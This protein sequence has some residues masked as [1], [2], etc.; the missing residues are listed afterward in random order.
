[1]WPTD[2]PASQLPYIHLTSFLDAFLC[3]RQAGLGGTL[4][5]MHLHA[6][7]NTD[8]SASC[9][10]PDK[11]KWHCYN[12]MPVLALGQ[13]F[14]FLLLASYLKRCGVASRG[15]RRFPYVTKDNLVA[16]QFTIRKYVDVSEEVRRV[17]HG[18]GG[19]GGMRVVLI[20]IC[21]CISCVCWH[22]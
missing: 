3:L 10:K 17:E 20:Q 1:M 14:V 6:I 16:E 9:V 21:L 4:Q 5:C 2:P 12:C 15:F 18:C 19:M 7:P 8:I 11:V 13:D 22:H